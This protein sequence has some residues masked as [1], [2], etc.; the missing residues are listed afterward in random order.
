MAKLKMPKWKL[1]LKKFHHNGIV[2]F[3]TLMLSMLPLYE[4][5][6]ANLISLQP[7]LG[8]STYKYVGLAVVIFNIVLHYTKK[9]LEQDDKPSD[10]E[11]P[12][13][14]NTES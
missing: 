6:S 8:D 11:G 2:W 7:Y 3:N 13:S 12:T 5:I 14:G 1:K 9:E 4:V 10:N